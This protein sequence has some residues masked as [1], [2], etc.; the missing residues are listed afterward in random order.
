MTPSLKAATPKTKETDKFDLVDVQVIIDLL[1][2]TKA[3]EEIESALEQLRTARWN[4]DEIY[5]TLFRNGEIILQRCAEVAGTVYWTW[6]SDHYLRDGMQ[7]RARRVCRFIEWFYYH[8]NPLDRASLKKWPNPNVVQALQNRARAKAREIPHLFNP[9]QFSDILEDLVLVESVLAKLNHVM[10]GPQ[11]HCVQ[12]LIPEERSLDDIRT[13]LRRAEFPSALT[14]DRTGAVD[15][16]EN[17]ISACV[18]SDADCLLHYVRETNQDKISALVKAS[19]AVYF[20]TLPPDHG[21]ITDSY[22]SLIPVLDKLSGD[23]E[24][25][26]ARMLWFKKSI[27]YARLEFTYDRSSSFIEEESEEANHGES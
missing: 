20:W 27:G 5:H 14:S 6:G 7:E 12:C 8:I 26:D 22:K 21:I 3:K 9:L 15:F 10:L 2:E 1:R 23:L 13:I 19:S 25:S 17:L 4:E 18:I 16:V 11:D 24:D